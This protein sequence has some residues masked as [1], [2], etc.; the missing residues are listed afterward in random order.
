MAHR[1]LLVDDDE[2][3]G[4]LFREYLSEDDFLVKVASSGK[5][6]LR[7][8]KEE[9]FELFLIDL[10]MPEMDGLQLLQELRALKIDEPAVLLTAYGVDLDESR[11]RELNITGFIPKGISMSEVSSEIKNKISKTKRQGG[12]DGRNKDTGG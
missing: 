5:E 12:G 10:V 8:V 6:A 2:T 9:R 3:I 11:K 1:I 7:I 4:E